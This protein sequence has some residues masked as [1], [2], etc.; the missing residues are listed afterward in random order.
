MRAILRLSAQPQLLD[1]LGIFVRRAA[2]QVVEKLAARIA[3]DGQS[4]A[5]SMIGFVRGEM[6]AQAVDALG[7]QGNLNLGGTGVARTALKFTDDS[8]LF[9]ASKWHEIK[10]QS[11]T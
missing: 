7:Q 6:L 3:Q 9:F 5:R 4:A 8:A 10:P 2:L 1:Q 11:I